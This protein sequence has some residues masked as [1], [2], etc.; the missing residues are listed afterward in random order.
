ML[1]SLTA[2]DPGDEQTEDLWWNIQRKC[3]SDPEHVADLGGHYDAICLNG[4]RKD[5][6]KGV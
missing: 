3:L 5:M 6:F 4:A 1:K 2:R